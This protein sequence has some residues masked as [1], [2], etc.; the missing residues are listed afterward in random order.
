METYTNSYL[1]TTLNRVKE[2]ILDTSQIT[3]YILDTITRMIVYDKRDRY[4]KY[5]I[6][7]EQ[8][9][10]I[11][12]NDNELTKK[13]GPE[14]LTTEF[15]GCKITKTPSSIDDT[16]GASDYSIKFEQEVLIEGTDIIVSIPLLEVCSVRDGSRT[17][18]IY[19]NFKE[20]DKND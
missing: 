20:V 3:K 9:E 17:F 8:T 19:F 7:T 12:V 10:T 16:P 5:L 18:T 4:V 1:Q 14:Y 15:V 2:E 6:A 13:F 11:T